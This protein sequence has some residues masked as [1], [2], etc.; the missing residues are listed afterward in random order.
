MKPKVAPGFFRQAFCVFVLSSTYMIIGTSSSWPTVIPKILNDTSSN[1]NLTDQDIQWLIASE[2]VSSMFA[3]AMTGI[4]MEVLGPRRL[5]SLTVMPTMVVWLLMAYVPSKV[6][7]FIGRIVIG[8]LS[9]SVSTS[10]SPFTAELTSPE[11]RGMLG[12]VRK[13][14]GSVGNLY[15][16][17][18][19]TFVPW[20]LATALNAA[21]LLP[22]AILFFF[23]K[24]SPYWLARHRRE[25]DARQA[26]SF[27]RGPKEDVCEE[28][29]R[30]RVANEDQPSANMKEQIIQMRLPSNYKPTLLSFLFYFVSV[31]GGQGIIFQYTV[32]LF[33]LARLDLDPFRCTILVGVGGLLSTIVSIFIVDLIDRRP[34]VITSSLVCA[35]CLVLT[36][37]S[38]MFPVLPSWFIVVF[39]VTYVVSLNMGVNT[40]PTIVMSEIVPTPVRFLGTS[41]SCNVYLC[42][43]FLASITFPLM[44]SG[45]GLEFSF[46]IFA[47]F[48]ILLAIIFYSLVPETRGRSLVELQYA[49]SGDKIGTDDKDL[50]CSV[51]LFHSKE[52]QTDFYTT[53]M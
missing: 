12:S 31:M 13:I 29:E 48:N 1:F 15:M 27:L 36:S 10:V 3:P 35:T 16:Y 32:F 50:E 18:T 6:V 25:D 7:L 9:G 37:L 21:P 40:L 43:M 22:T 4:L 45:V 51:H 5:L 34:L 47:A 14:F 42:S 53:E 17:I 2:P 41:M 39:V 28:L 52:E 44:V 46:L 20:Q 49:F 38:M 8:I 30:I 19:A 24:E 23:V 33:Q 26:L 11:V